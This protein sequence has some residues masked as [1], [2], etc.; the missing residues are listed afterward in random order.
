MT[1]FIDI[2]QQLLTLNAAVQ[3]RDATSL[4]DAAIPLLQDKNKAESMGKQAYTLLCA[5][6]G[7]VAK[8]LDV[9]KACGLP[10]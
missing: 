3:V 4:Y 10:C 5:N 8:T 1:D 2:S 6:R 9:I 7:A